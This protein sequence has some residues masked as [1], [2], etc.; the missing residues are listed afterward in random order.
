MIEKLNSKS[1]LEHVNSEFKVE[2]PNAQ[3]LSLRLTEVAE[4]DSGPRSEQ[5]SLFFLGPKTPLLEQRIYALK[6]EKLGELGL[7][8]TPIAMEPEGVLYEC[9]FNRLRKAQPPAS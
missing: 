2:A 3:V 7:F 9:V 6:H 8:L 1:F 4:R 5:F